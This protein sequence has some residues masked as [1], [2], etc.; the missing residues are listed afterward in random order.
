ML[1]NGRSIPD[2]QS[3][4]A[5]LGKILMVA[6]LICAIGG[7]W[8]VLQSVAWANM[9]AENAGTS[10]IG[11]AIVKTFDGKHPCCLCKQIAQSRQSEKKADWQSSLKKFEFPSQST[12]FFIG[13]P[14]HFY[15]QAD[16]C[17]TAPLLA[18]TPPVPPPRSLQG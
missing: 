6:A 7:H 5:R 9:L 12:A 4:F 2:K 17:A 15:L 11:E 18:E 3:V 14:V 1:D 16:F 10:S 13:A 8:V